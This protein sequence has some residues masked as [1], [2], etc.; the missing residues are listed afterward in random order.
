MMLDKVGSRAPGPKQQQSTSHIDASPW[1]VLQ[2]LVRERWREYAGRYAAALLLMAIASGATAL[3]AWIM[4]DIVN[5][6]F[7]DRD[8]AAMVWLPFV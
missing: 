1:Q 5:D 2:R 3:T 8:Q 4:K 6:I 7:V